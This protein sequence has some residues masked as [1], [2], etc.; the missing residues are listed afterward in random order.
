MR[1]HAARND[2]S[3]GETAPRRKNPLDPATKWPRQGEPVAYVQQRVKTNH[4]LRSSIWLIPLGCHLDTGPGRRKPPHFA[5]EEPAKGGSAAARAA[6]PQSR[7]T[8]AQGRPR[9][10]IFEGPKSL[11]PGTRRKSREPRCGGRSRSAAAAC[12]GRV[13]GSSRASQAAKI[14]RSRRSGRAAR[15]HPDIARAFDDAHEI[16]DGFELID[17]L[18]V[19]SNPGHP[20]FD[21]DHQLEPIEPVGPEVVA[22]TRLF[23]QAIRGNPELVG[24][25]G[26][27]LDGRAS[28]WRLFIKEAAV[29]RKV[30]YFVAGI[31]ERGAFGPGRS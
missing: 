31:Q 30:S 9:W 8:A 17:H 24:D 13:H 16:A 15:L 2:A 19:N 7:G 28:P 27:D 26:A 29:M 1:A 3:N 18:V 10:N 11:S 12:R 22:Q 20:I 23:R 14:R 5:L 25:N 6:S 21:R 4:R